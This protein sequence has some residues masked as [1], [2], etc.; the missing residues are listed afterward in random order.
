MHRRSRGQ[1]TLDIATCV[2]WWIAA[3][4]LV[5]LA[6]DLQGGEFIWCR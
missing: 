1:L 4:A 3:V 6:R 5:M 2:A